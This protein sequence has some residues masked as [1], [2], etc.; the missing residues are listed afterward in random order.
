MDACCLI[1]QAEENGRRRLLVRIKWQ[2]KQ[3]AADRHVTKQGGLRGDGDG[4]GQG[5][6][7]LDYSLGRGYRARPVPH[8]ELT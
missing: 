2:C 8:V 7:D 5:L 6:E 1:H 4:H 3:Q